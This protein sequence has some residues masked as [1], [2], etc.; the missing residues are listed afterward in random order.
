V[1]YTPTIDPLDSAVGFWNSWGDRWGLHGRFYMTVRTWAS[2]LTADG[3][4]TVPV[5]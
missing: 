4:V 5:R 3:D 2:L 1:S